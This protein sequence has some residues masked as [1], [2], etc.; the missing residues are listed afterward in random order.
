MKLEIEA[1]LQDLFGGDGYTRTIKVEAKRLSRKRTTKKARNDI[2]SPTDR[3]VQETRTETKDEPVHTFR[4]IDGKPVYRLGGSSGKLLGAMKEADKFLRMFGDE[5]RNKLPVAFVRVY[6]AWVPLKNV[7]GQHV[8]G[9]PQILNGYGGSTM[10]VQSFDVIEQAKVSFII[11]Y[12]DSVDERVR[13]I[14]ETLQTM[15]L[16]NK[17]RGSIRFDKITEA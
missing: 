11:E 6:P 3:S 17:P 9:L 10:I 13:K 4:T 1:T 14:L 5:G 16:G 8:E 15:S 12:P 2:G 7:E